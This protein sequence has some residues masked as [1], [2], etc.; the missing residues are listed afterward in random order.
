VPT[1]TVPQYCG[2][3]VRDHLWLFTSDACFRAPHQSSAQLEGT[4][5]DETLPAADPIPSSKVPAQSKPV[6][7]VGRYERDQG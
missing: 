1:L 5:I 4:V 3:I 6:A 2:S 7:R